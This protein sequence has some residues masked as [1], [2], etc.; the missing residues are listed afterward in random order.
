MFLAPILLAA[1]SAAVQH[2]DAT[3]SKQLVPM[4]TE[5]LKFRTYAHNDEARDAQQQWVMKTAQSLGL[6]ARDAG[7]VVEIEL[8]ATVP[9]API[10][11]LVVHGDV[12]PVVVSAVRRTR[13]PRLRLRTRRRRRQGTA[14]AGAA[15]DARH[16]RER[17]ENAH[18]HDPAARRQR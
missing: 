8:P 7:K 13:R 4:L 15:G 9:D 2:Y 14:R 12:Q 11:G 18:A 3:E 5:V 1:V 17:A 10:L 16:Q 6:E